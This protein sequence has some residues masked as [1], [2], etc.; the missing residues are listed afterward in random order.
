MII[1]KSNSSNTTASQSGIGK[2]GKYLLRF[3]VFVGLMWGAKQF[4]ASI[5]KPL[6]SQKPKKELSKLTKGASNMP[7]GVISCDA[8]TVQ[9]G[10]FVGVD[11]RLFENGQTQS[12]E[13][14]R[15]GEKSCKIAP[16]QQY[17]IG[18][19]ITNPRPNEA[20]YISVW[21]YKVKGD[22]AIIAASGN[23]GSDFYIQSNKTIKKDSLGWELL[24]LSFKIPMD[25]DIADL[26][27]Y[28][29]QQ[30]VTEV[31]L[32]DMTIEKK[33]GETNTEIEDVSQYSPTFSLEIADKWMQKLRVK[34]KEAFKKG[35]LITEDDDWVKG[36]ILTDS[37]NAMGE[38]LK[39]PVKLRLKGDW[40]DHLSGNK[41]SYRIQVK[42]PYAWNR[43]KTFSIQNSSTRGQL[44]EWVYHQWLRKEDV[45]SP[46]YDFIQTTVNG[47]KKGVYAYEEHFDKQLPE[48]MKRREG[49]IVRF[50]EDG[51]WGFKQR[52]IKTLG[53]E[54]D[55]HL[56]EEHGFKATK[57]KVFKEG[58]TLKSETLKQQFEVAQNLMQQY[59]YSTQ[60]VADVFDIE[61]LAKYFAISDL[62]QSHHSFRWHNQRFYYNPISTRLE[63]VGFDGGKA[64]PLPKGAP[65]L[66]YLIWNE[67]NY[68]EDLVKSLFAD[69]EFVAEYVS[70]LRKF[71]DENY[72]SDFLQS[73][74]QDLAKR[75]LMIQ[76]EF[77]DYS[78]KRNQIPETAK[79]I[80]AYI[81]PLDTESL[82]VF[83]QKKEGG[84]QQLQLQNKHFLPLQIL[85]FGKTKG[86][87]TTDL[88]KSIYVPVNKKGCLPQYVKAA[89]ELDMNYVYFKQVGG[90]ELLS[91][92]INKWRTPSFETPNQSLF[93]GL[94]LES[95][96]IYRVVEETK[97]I[98]FEAGKYQSK[99]NLILPAGYEVRMEAGC[100]LD[101]IEGAAFV[102]KSPVYLHGEEENPIKIYSSDQTANGFTVLQ[103]DKKSVLN[104][105]LFEDLNTMNQANWTLTG[106]VSFYESDVDIS[107]CTFTKNHCE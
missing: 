45:L 24:E 101:L 98:V 2:W 67:D 79:R 105:V 69:E 61:R 20:F 48:F 42:D 8:E 96:A 55:N 32:D 39:M 26:K 35:L 62:C 90:E 71:S 78:Y 22:N 41:W 19:I 50:T 46:R 72:L 84:K 68:F 59:Q 76:Q 70:Y 99:E 36:N 9:E 53:Y 57:V 4:F 51:F 17:G 60:K 75:E 77:V 1:K 65:F 10:K 66:G 23:K 58:K 52:Q 15:S 29:Y 93:E 13:K 87:M 18:Y 12:S 82:T 25:K 106:A 64:I 16:N 89:S 30:G 14:A 95:N 49:V 63:P 94:Q 88:P 73:I 3:L 92:N 86:E 5:S 33:G 85:G 103:S 81:S 40:L 100:H 102:S 43:L 27:I 44:D 107:Y 97:T 104:Y 7:V 11:K 91:S 38:K 6:S 47:E 31:Y 74:D 56:T 37:L 83:V 54:S 28:A 34:R 21:Q 80:R